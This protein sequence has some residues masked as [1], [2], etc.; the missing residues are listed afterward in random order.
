MKSVPKNRAQVKADF[1]RRGMTVQGW[2]RKNGFH[3][4]TVT[5]VLAGKSLNRYGDCHKIAVMLGMK[6]GVI[7]ES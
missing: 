3:R 7:E 5:R 4:S 1:E 2:A 6:K